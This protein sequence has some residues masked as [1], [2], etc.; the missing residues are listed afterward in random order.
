MNDLPPTT[1]ADR[2]D[3]IAMSLYGDFLDGERTIRPNDRGLWLLAVWDRFVTEPL[4]RYRI[5][6][7]EHDNMVD[8]SYAGPDSGC[9]GGHCPDCGYSY[10]HVLY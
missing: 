9:I 4:M 5:K 1:M 3:Y 7:C 6:H 8:E 10:H 2:M